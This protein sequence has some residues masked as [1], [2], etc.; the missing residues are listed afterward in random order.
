MSTLGEI[1]LFTGLKN[2]KI[3]E[4]GGELYSALRCFMCV[5]V[6]RMRSN[7]PK[8]EEKVVQIWL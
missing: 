3:F 4:V 1:K 6:V 7:N 8:S 5:D 2:P